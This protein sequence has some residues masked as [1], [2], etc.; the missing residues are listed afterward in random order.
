MRISRSNLAEMLALV[1]SGDTK[2]DEVKAKFKAATGSDPTL[3]DQ[4]LAAATC[5]DDDDD[6]EL[7]KNIIDIQ[8]NGLVVYEDESSID[9]DEK[10]F[11]KSD[12]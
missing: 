7:I 3:S 12:N 4:E 11:V 5:T 8:A 1:Q 6:D 9:E 2:L 10:E